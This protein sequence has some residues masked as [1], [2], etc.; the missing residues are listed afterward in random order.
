LLL[1]NNPAL[2]PLVMPAP[3]KLLLSEQTSDRHGA[4]AIVRRETTGIDIG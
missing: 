3:H 1:R 4:F 2:G